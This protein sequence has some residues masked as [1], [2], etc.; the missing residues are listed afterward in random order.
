MRR[1]ATR[2]EPTAGL[3]DGVGPAER[4]RRARMRGCTDAQPTDGSAL[5]G[6]RLVALRAHTDRDPGVEGGF[7]GFHVFRNTAGPAWMPG[8]PFCPA[9][10]GRGRRGTGR[11]PVGGGACGHGCPR[12][13]GPLFG[14][15]RLQPRGTTPRDR[16][17]CLRCADRTLIQPALPRSQDRSSSRKAGRRDG[18]ASETAC[19]PHEC[20]PEADRPTGRSASRSKV[21]ASA[22]RLPLR[23]VCVCA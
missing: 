6:L 21:S 7:G 17:R 23:G 11:M 1:P 19:V 10:N 4:A 14:P 8:S 18:R 15:L 9:H 12:G 22:T 2:P 16:F 20:G 5:L 3:G 13:S